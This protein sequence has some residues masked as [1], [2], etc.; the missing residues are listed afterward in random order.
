VSRRVSQP[1]PPPPA[2]LTQGTQP[3]LGAVSY[4]VSTHRISGG[5]RN[6]AA[7]KHGCRL[8]VRGWP[9][10]LPAST[11]CELDLPSEPPR[12]AQS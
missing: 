4:V 2:D 6:H 10:V 9:E 11:L 8:I 5:Y 3:I 1:L 12:P 7:G